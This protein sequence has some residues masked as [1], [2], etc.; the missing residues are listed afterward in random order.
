MGT[1]RLQDYQD[2]I[3][4]MTGRPTLD[5]TKIARWVNAAQMEFGY[6]FKFKELEGTIAVPT[7]AG[8][9]TYTMDTSVRMLR[10]S[11]TWIRDAVTGN[12]LAKLRKETRENWERRASG[13]TSDITLRGQPGYYHRYGRNII[14][15]AA[16]DKVY[17][18]TYDCWLKVTKFVLTT[19][20]SMFDEDW[21]DII[22]TGGAYRAFRAQGEHDRY[23]NLRNDFLG[24]VRSRTL[25][26]DIEEFPEGGLNIITSADQIELDVDG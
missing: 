9:V 6:A 8:V 19:D 4:S 24:M 11:G 18:L 12:R 22:L 1:Y 7:V 3:R 14:L 5:G 10:E 16:P 21:D 20:V 25:D 26:E 2:E 13:P 15:R 23:I 17:T